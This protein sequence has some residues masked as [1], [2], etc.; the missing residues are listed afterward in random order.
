[1]P[2]SINVPASFSCHL[3]NA[4]S[5]ESSERVDSETDEAL[6]SREID[7]LIAAANACLEGAAHTLTSA[8]QADREWNDNPALPSFDE[9]TNIV[10]LSRTV[11]S[12]MRSF[13]HVVDCHSEYMPSQPVSEQDFSQLSDDSAPSSMEPEFA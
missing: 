7:S 9:I 13:S 12:D 3:L 10:E 8:E 11:T 2:L 6:C 4:A 1:M 5:H